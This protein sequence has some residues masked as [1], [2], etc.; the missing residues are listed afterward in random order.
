MERSSRQ[1]FVVGRDDFGFSP[2]S[3]SE[4]QPVK[5]LKTITSELTA[6][7]EN[8]KYALLD[9]R[10]MIQPLLDNLKTYP[11]KE[12][13]HWVKRAEQVEVFEAKLNAFMKEILGDKEL[14]E[15]PA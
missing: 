9:L 5:D 1:Q 12:Y 15:I 14:S 8:L 13:L 6:E 7:N 4:I 3:E 10:D 11:E 2:K